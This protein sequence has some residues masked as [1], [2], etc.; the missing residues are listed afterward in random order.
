MRKVVIS[1]AGGPLRRDT[2]VDRQE[3]TSQVLREGRE[4]MGPAKLKSFLTDVS[5]GA[6]ARWKA[7]VGKFF[8]AKPSGLS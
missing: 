1:E 7:E 4:I 3:W 5:E 8:A 2:F 6:N